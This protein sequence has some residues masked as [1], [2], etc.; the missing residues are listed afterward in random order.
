MV[1][2]A[3]KNYRDPNKWVLLRKKILK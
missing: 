2:E 3:V 1:S